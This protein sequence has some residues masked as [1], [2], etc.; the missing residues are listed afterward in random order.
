MWS[1]VL[2]LVVSLV[3]ILVY[4]GQMEP[5]RESGGWGYGGVSADLLDIY[6]VSCRIQ[7]PDE[8]SAGDL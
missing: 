6:R 7:L 4:R 5:S 8:I 3:H 1:G 2:D